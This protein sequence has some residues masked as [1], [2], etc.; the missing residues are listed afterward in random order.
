MGRIADAGLTILAASDNDQCGNC[1]MNKSNSGKHCCKDE[2]KQ[3][4]ISLDQKSTSLDYTIVAPHVAEVSNL[5]PLT[6][7]DPIQMELRMAYQS[8]APPIAELNRQSLLCVF[9]I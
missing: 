3:L 7:S 9:R 4:K 5:W 8:H 1:G 2:Y 6:I